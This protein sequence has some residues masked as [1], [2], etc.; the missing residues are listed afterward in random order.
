[1]TRAIHEALSAR[2]VLRRYY[3][4]SLVYALAGGFLAGVYPLFLKARGLGQLEINSVLQWRMAGTL[5][6]LAA[7]CDF[8]LR[9]SRAG[10]E[11][12]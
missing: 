5:A 7:P 6:L 2:A 1:V 10:L 12:P 4:V 11:P 8:A 9:P 3:T